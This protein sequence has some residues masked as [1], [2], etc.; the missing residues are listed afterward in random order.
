VGGDLYDFFFIDEDHLCFAIG[1]V[2]DKG[3]PAALFMV[4]TKTLIN[5]SAQK[6]RSPAEMMIRINNVLSSDNPKSMF[7]TLIIGIL[8]IRTGEVHYSNGGHNLP[9][10]IHA[11]KKTI[12]QK[13]LSGLV[14]GVMDNIPYKD[15]SFTMKPGDALFLYTDGVTEAMN[16]KNELFS[17][18]RLLVEMEKLSGSPVEKTLH[19]MM[20]IIKDHSATAPQSDDIAMMMIRYNGSPVQILE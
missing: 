6:N 13:G 20:D 10:L 8:N 15:L 19:R 9:V 1:D 16:P 5:T 11:N 3:V 4:I 14:V 17:D 18:E 12:F 2:S 7:V